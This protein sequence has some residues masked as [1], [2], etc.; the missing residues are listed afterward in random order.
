LNDRSKQLRTDGKR[1]DILAAAAGTFR[2]LGVQRAGMREIADAVGLSTGNLY[3]YF[4]NKDELIYYCQDRTLDALL[5]VARTAGEQYGSR[6]QLGY[7][8]EG[9]LRVVLDEQASGLLHLEFDELPPELRKKVVQ[10]RDRYERAVRALIADGQK[11]NEVRPGNPKLDAFV[12]LGALNWAARWFRPNGEWTVDEVARHHRSRLLD[13]LFVGGA[14]L[15]HPDGLPWKPPE[16]VAKKPSD[17]AMKKP[18]ENAA[19]KPSDG[20]VKKLPGIAKRV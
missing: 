16:I 4:R 14:P 12:L 2:K 10:K 15:L 1:R 3:Y 20:A 13:G 6:G 19:K 8:I 7:L 9:H 5:A 17:G 11:R 18:L